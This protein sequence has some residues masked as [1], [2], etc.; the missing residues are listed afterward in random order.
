M[1]PALNSG[2]PIAVAVSDGAAVRNARPLEQLNEWAGLVV[3][4]LGEGREK[5]LVH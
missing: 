3:R 5:R 2:L 4:R 1:C